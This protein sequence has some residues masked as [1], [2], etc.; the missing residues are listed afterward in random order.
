MLTTLGGVEG[1]VVGA[2]LLV[3]FNDGRAEVHGVDSI[4]GTAVPPPSRRGKPAPELSLDPPP[5]AAPMGA[6]MLSRRDGLI[7][8]AVMRMIATISRQKMI[9]FV[10]LLGVNIEDAMIVAKQQRRRRRLGRLDDLPKT[11]RER[12]GEESPKRSQQQREEKNTRQPQTRRK[13]GVGATTTCS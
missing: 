9:I 2:E 10:T 3:G 12:T 1:T 6:L 5:A 11:S 8:T 13:E 4:D 7:I